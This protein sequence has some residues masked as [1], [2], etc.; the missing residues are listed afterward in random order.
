MGGGRKGRRDSEELVDILEE[1]TW[2]SK[3]AREPPST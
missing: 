2:Q 1:C 3:K